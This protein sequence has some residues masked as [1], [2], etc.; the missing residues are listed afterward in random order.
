MK[1][2][3]RNTI[4]VAI[5][6]V[7]FVL[8]FAGPIAALA[9]TTPSLGAAAAY[10]VLGST[11]TNTTAGTTIN[12]GVGFTTGP[13]VAPLGTHI[14]YGSGAPYAIAGADQGSALSALASQLCTFTFGGGAINLSTD[15]TH[16][17]AGVYVPGVYCSSGAMDIGGPLTLNGSGTYIFRPVGALTSTAGATVTLTGASACDV[18]WTPT[19][20]ATF[21]ANTTLAGTV[22]SNA[23]VTVGANT[24][25]TGRSLAFGGT[26]TTDTNTITVPTCG[27]LPATLNVVKLVVNGGG[28]AAISSS[29]S[30]H[31]KNSSSTEVSGSP[32]A[33]VAAPGI[34]YSLAAG[35][36]AVSED[37][38]TS[39]V[40]SFSGACNSSGNVTLAAGE[41]RT[42][43]I[44]NTFVPLA[45]PV[46]IG[47]GGGRIIPLIGI[48]KVPTPLALPA[49][50][51]SV[52]YNYTAWNVGGQQSLTN[53]TLTD[54][55]C[56][57][58]NF[59]SGDL[60]NN[61]KLDPGEYW[62]YSC[63]ATL[64]N[65]TTN[66]AIAIGHSDDGANQA[67][68]ATAIATVVVGAPLTPPLINIIKVPDRLTPFPFGGGDVT[69][70]YT[71]IN[72]GVVAL[73]DVVVTDDKCAPV[74]R[75]SGD[76]NSNNLLEPSEIWAYT[77]RTNVPASTR[78]IATAE[79]KAN[80]LTALGYAFADVLVTTPSL[81]DAGFLPEDSTFSGDII[82]ISG[83]LLFVLT[84][85]AVISKE[86]TV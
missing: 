81:P 25:W 40:R 45:A 54:D 17:T 55:K 43:T 80:G 56:A 84:A 15:I 74:S 24:T 73:H 57:P 2:P 37:A 33:G 77:C 61:A 26:I 75:I 27:S 1:K 22:I 10:G 52:I 69:Y 41:N 64:A 28:G 31:V 72:P 47:A 5:L 21:A 83:L 53:V 62:K 85:L 19:Q 11:Y 59:V 30:V 13:A 79:G 36:Y 8:G 44:V 6:T 63:A 68:I 20:A 16:G 34:S 71:V 3:S 29:F 70:A 7:V 18:F 48:V 9:A 46:L 49:G 23:G 76:L 60:N 51:G 65:T 67:T 82:V 12:G 50:P 42:C 39:Y 66:T 86:R 4:I 78:N 38:N 58:V 35:T 14:N 32:A